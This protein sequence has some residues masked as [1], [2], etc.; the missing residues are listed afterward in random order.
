V[1]R[2]SR[3]SHGRPCI[4]CGRRTYTPSG[5]CP[6]CGALPP[7]DRMPESFLQACAEELLRRHQARGKLLERLGIRGAA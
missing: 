7:P 6:D 2:A 5:L 4:A 1:T 3:K